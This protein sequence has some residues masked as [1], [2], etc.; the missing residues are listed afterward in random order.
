MILIIDS[1][2]TKTSW[3]LCGEGSI[4]ALLHTAGLNPCTMSSDA[5]D[6][7]L[8]DPALL[9]LT[10]RQHQIDHIFYYGA[11]CGDSYGQ[12]A[13]AAKLHALFPSLSEEAVSGDG[14]GDGEWFTADGMNECYLPCVETD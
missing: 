8:R 12:N 10:T 7:V 3:Q 11:G 4:V 5:I 14:S 6:A 1:G 9:Q 13:I 2:S